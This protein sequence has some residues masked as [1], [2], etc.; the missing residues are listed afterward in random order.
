MTLARVLADPPRP[1]VCDSADTMEQATPS[2]ALERYIRYHF[3]PSADEM[4]SLEE[5]YLFTVMPSETGSIA[6]ANLKGM[7]LSGV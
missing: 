7:G 2:D 5:T 3:F 6:A 4:A 1:M